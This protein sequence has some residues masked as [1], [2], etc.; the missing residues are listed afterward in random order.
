MLLNILLNQS[1]SDVRQKNPFVR[2]DRLGNAVIW[3]RQ[4]L[5]LGTLGGHEP[6]QFVFDF[7]PIPIGHSCLCARQSD[8]RQF[9]SVRRPHSQ[10]LIW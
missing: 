7:F 2:V 9:T 5:A 10:S 1:V 3:R 4:L 8:W 6:G